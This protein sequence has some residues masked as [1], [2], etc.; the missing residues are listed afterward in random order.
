MSMSD[1]ISDMLTR[2]RNAQMVNKV[3]VVMPSSRVKAAIAQ[4]LKDEGYIEDFSVHTER[5]HTQLQLSLKYYAGRPVI[6]RIKRI[7]RPS[8]PIYKSARNIPQLMNGLGT[9]IVSTTKGVMTD[10][11]AR[12]LGI[13]GEIMCMVE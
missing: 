9:V 12:S 2:V 11:H 10:R 8:R 5:S 1:P 6:S 7:S 3:S 13:G 4:V